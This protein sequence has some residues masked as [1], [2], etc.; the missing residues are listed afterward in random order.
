MSFP[1][2]QFRVTVGGM[3]LCGVIT[4][5]TQNVAG[6]FGSRDVAPVEYTAKLW[7]D[8]TMA[9][10]DQGT[11]PDGGIRDAQDRPK[12]PTIGERV[13]EKM[14][15]LR[16]GCTVCITLPGFPAYHFTLPMNAVRD[17]EVERLRRIIAAAIDQAVDHAVREHAEAA[18][19]LDRQTRRQLQAIINESNERP[20]VRPDPGVELRAAETPRWEYREVNVTMAFG[21]IFPI[22]GRQGWEFVGTVSYLPGGQTCVFKRRL[23]T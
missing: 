23:A 5:C 20:V 3:R 18:A 19:E 12:T 15:F 7:E 11:V 10:N 14:V 6:T 9:A 2:E 4:E 17:V 21:D 8:K 13:A 16:A 1:M 22:L